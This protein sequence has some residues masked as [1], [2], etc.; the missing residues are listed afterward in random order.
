MD[1]Y[2]SASGRFC[3]VW[4]SISKLR[5]DMHS[6]EFDF[7]VIDMDLWSVPEEIL[8]PS[9]A[10]WLGLSSDRTFQTTYRALQLK[11]E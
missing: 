6:K 10:R 8:L 3:G 7:Y 1:D 5:N 2:I 9:G 4:G 11:A